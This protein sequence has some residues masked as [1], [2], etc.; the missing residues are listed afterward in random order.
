LCLKLLDLPASLLHTPAPG[1]RLRA[2]R[3]S[4]EHSFPWSTC[5]SRAHAMQ[6]VLWDDRGMKSQRRNGCIPCDGK[7]TEEVRLRVRPIRI[8]L[9]A[10]PNCAHFPSAQRLIHSIILRPLRHL[11]T[12]A[13]RATICLKVQRFICILYSKAVVN[14]PSQ[15][16]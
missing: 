5:S 3:Y 4:P 11:D 8:E 6:R 12:K 14:A 10:R 13:D 9:E 1:N 2:Q 7:V 15:E 16:A